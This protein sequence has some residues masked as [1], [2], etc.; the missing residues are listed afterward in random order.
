MHLK[1]Y[2]YTLEKFGKEGI[3]QYADWFLEKY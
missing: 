2:E 3:D 1:A